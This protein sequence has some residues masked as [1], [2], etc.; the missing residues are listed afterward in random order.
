MCYPTNHN[1]LT[2]HEL[3]ESWTAASLATDLSHVNRLKVTV[4]IFSSLLSPSIVAPEGTGGRNTPA[5]APA[6]IVI[7][8]PEE[9]SIFPPEITAPTVIWHDESQAAAKWQIDVEFTDGLPGMRV[10]A[11]GSR[12]PLGDIDPR[13]VAETNE[14]PRLTPRDAA[15]R[16]WKPDAETWDSIKRRSADRPATVTI[17]GLSDDSQDVSRGRVSIMTSTDPVGAPIFYRDVPLMPSELEKGVIKPLVP[18][19]VPLIS[20][21]LRNIGEPRSRLLMEGL[22]TCA[23]CHSFSLDG[24]TLGMDVDG[25]QNDKGMYAIVPVLR[26]TFI[27]TGDVF[28]WNSF[29][30]KPPGQRTIGFMA[31]VSPD[32]RYAVTTLNEAMYV[33]NF[34]DYRFL[35]VFYPTR[36]IIAWYQRATGVMKALPGADNPSFVQTDSVWSPDGDSLVFARAPAKD[37]YP[38]GRRL[39]EYANDP[40]EVPIKYDLFRVPFNHGRGGRPRPIAGASGNGVSNSFPKVSP[41]GRWIVFVQSRNGQL[42]R[43]DGQL[44]IVPAEGGTARRMR[45]NT[46][47]MNSWH[48]FSPN[49]RWLVFTSKSRSPYTRMFLTHLDRDGRDSPAIMVEETTAA[50]RAVNLPEFVNIPQD[51]LSKIEVPAA[52]FYRLFDSAWKLAEAGQYKASVAEWEKA[53]ALSPG[54]AKAHNNLGRALAGAGD[55][56]EAMV[57][58]QKALE[59]DP[60]YAEARN[61]LGVALIREGKLDDAIAQFRRI[62]EANSGYA[63]VH[64]NLGHALERKGKLDK[65]IEQWHMALQIKPDFAQAHSNL[66][67]ALY[68]RGRFTDALDQWR[69]LLRNQPDNLPA[70]KQAAWI[71]AT[72]PVP[73][74]RNGSEAVVLAERALKSSGSPDPGVY[75][76]LAAAYAEIG[77]FQDAVRAADKALDLATRSGMD[78]LQKKLQARIALYQAGA[79]YREKNQP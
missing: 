51:S 26:R 57:H 14:L 9:G 46:P 41:D 42:M 17:T 8:Y 74:V 19:A 66:A 40:N 30:Q 56:S 68:L 49:G 55:F 72:C 37:P 11:A 69:A 25:P 62:L 15:A 32:G 54:D 2:R 27:R 7:D 12:L 67:N 52:E 1:A 76:T 65:A 16:S 70:L 3:H 44:Y 78:S 59:I 33:V 5:I 77:R 31:Q 39:A 73:S 29:P 58:W 60:N 53:L 23:N 71:L 21:R 79:P 24:R 48:S 28:S 10:A 63:E 45:C 38:E 20:W 36:G 61:N 64:N 18:S 50:N 13:C 35:Q 34:K 6:S 22:P 75:D 43:P 4:L 47:L